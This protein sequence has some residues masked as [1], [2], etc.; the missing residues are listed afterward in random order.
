MTW[1]DV[2]RAIATLVFLSALWVMAQA[3]GNQDAPPRPKAQF[4][5]GIVTDLGAKHVTV[6][7]SLVGRPRE[8]RTF[9]I[10]HR[11]KVSRPLRM[12]SRVTVRYVRMPEG[13]EALEIQVR[14]QTRPLHPA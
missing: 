5:A 13:D 6:S 1:R 9:M 10:T 8:N 12:K 7:R 2:T 14:S 3:P 4:F 11:T